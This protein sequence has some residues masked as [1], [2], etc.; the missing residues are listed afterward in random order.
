MSRFRFTTT[1]GTVYTLSD[2]TEVLVKTEPGQPLHEAT[3]MITGTLVRD[4]ARPLVHMKH[5]TD[6]AEPAGEK[7]TFARMPTVGE[8]FVYWHPSLA[9][10]ISTPV[11]E[12]EEL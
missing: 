12:I 7:V 3:P 9:G 6:M 11:V 10:C 5:G 2:H 8:N 4:G 1:S